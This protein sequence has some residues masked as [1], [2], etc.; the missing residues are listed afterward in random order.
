MAAVFP[1]SSPMDWLR[2]SSEEPHR[3]IIVYLQG[4]SLPHYGLM[5]IFTLECY[6]VL[7]VYRCAVSS[8][9]NPLQVQ[10]FQVNGHEKS[11]W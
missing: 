11:T 2:C 8:G 7:S 1:G 5:H 4:C 10:L 6:I 3:S 9:T